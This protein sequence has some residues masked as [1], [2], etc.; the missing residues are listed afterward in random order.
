MPDHVRLRATTEE[1]LL[2]FFQFQQD[3]EARYQAAFIS[4]DPDNLEAHTA[5]WAKV[6]D[7]PTISVRAVLLGDE[8]VGNI[9]AF[10]M[11]GELQVGY[12]IDKRY[13]GRNIATQALTQFLQL[14]TTRPLY[15]SAAADNTASIRVL[16]KCGF[17]PAGRITSFS[18][19]RNREIEEALF[20]LDDERRAIDDR[21]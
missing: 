19:A 5:H 6:M 21:R 8:V 10:P 16:Q 20:R 3:P 13:W 11:E 9:F 7:D 18:N 14:V 4:K 2:I 1:D 15:A 17:Q 12:W